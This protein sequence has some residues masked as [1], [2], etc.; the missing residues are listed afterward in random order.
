MEKFHTTDWNEKVSLIDKFSDERYSFFAKRLIYQEAPEVL[1]ENF[2]KEI[3]KILLAV[4]FQL[5][6]NNGQHS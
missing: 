2:K 5:T 3:M 1:P 4:C 6:N